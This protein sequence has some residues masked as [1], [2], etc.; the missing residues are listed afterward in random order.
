MSN[1]S[2]IYDN[3]HGFIKIDQIAKKIIDTPYFQRL[4]RIHQTG[5]LFFVIPSADHSRFIHSIGTYHLAREFITNLSKNQPELKITKR[6]ILLVSLA[7]LCHDLGHMF[8]SHLFDDMFLSNV[9]YNSKNS[10]HEYRSIFM[11]NHIVKKYKIELSENDLLVIGDLIYPY[12]NSYESWDEEF[13]VGKWIFEIISNPINNIDVD[14]FDYIDRD[15]RA[16]GL[17]LNFEYSRLISQAKVYENN[18]VYPKQVN[19]D[20]FNMFFIRYRLH[21]KIYNHKAVK[22]IELMLI[23]ALNEIE[24]E[25]KISEY[26]DD[27]DKILLLTDDYIY[28]NNNLKVKEIMDKISLRQIPSMIFEHISLSNFELDKKHFENLPFPDSYLKIIKFK[29]GYSSSKDNNPLDNVKFYETKTNKIV[30]INYPS[31]YSLI[32]KNEHLEYFYRIYIIDNDYYEL[33]KEYFSKIKI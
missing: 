33:A 11:L 23:D 16:S 1:E 29:V 17:K 6:L 32:I 12:E 20:I 9:N 28:H 21:R 2:L 7:G 27:P 3:I 13:K 14:K 31:D 15:N 26:I 25:R 8:Y 10:I 19:S 4:R 24:K 30:K 22:A 18:I 5:A